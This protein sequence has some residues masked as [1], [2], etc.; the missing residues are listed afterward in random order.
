MKLMA[1]ALKSLWSRRLAVTLTALCIALSVALL[2]SLQ[3][4]KNASEESFT[5]TVSQMDLLVGARSGQ[6][7]LLLFTVFNMG[8]PTH[9]VSWE[10]YEHWRAHPAVQWTI[11][12]SLGDSFQGFRVV[13]TDGN[14]FEHYRYQQTR[15]IEFS[16][17]RAFQEEGEMVLG[18]EVHRELKLKVHD[19]AIITH[20]VTKGTG[21]EKH[22]ENPMEIVGILSRTGTMLDH[23]V[24]ISLESMEHLHHEETENDE[25]HEHDHRLTTLTSFFVRTQN[26]MDSLHLQREISEYKGEPLMA[27]I[28]AV[29]LSELWKNLSFFERTLDFI[30]GLVAV[31]SI[32]TLMLMML[33]SMEARRREMAL[34]RALGA[35]AHFL[36]L[37]LFAEAIMVGL[38]GAT[39]GFVLSRLGLF[40][41]ADSLQSALGVSVSVWSVDPLEILFILAV[42]I[43]C[44]LVSL[45]PGWRASRQALKDGLTIKN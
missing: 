28:P 15:A 37:L 26:R 20:G 41:F 19:K 34:M 14:F 45:F 36:I 25:T 10:S 44:G 32:M 18:Y 27:V 43:G 6:L 38:A 29:A 4:I 3:R 7:Q 40:Y 11:P 35:T 39:V 23:S 31:F 16:A 30:I 24:F 2:L 17:G 9:N 33:A 13:G 12:F 5:Q 1:I 8:Q 42:L 22:D 21:I